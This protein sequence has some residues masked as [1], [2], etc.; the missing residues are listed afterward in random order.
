MSEGGVKVADSGSNL[1]ISPELQYV[2]ETQ[3]LYVFWLET[4]A[5]QR[6][7]G[8]SGQ[9]MSPTG[10]LLW[11]NNGSNFVELSL[12]EITM[13]T[14]KLVG[15]DVLVFYGAGNPQNILETQLEVMLINS[16]GEQVW[17]NEKS[18]LSSV[19]SNSRFAHF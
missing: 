2:P 1:Q 17:E 8:I 19:P 5:R 7:R 9:K 11:A 10:E 18:M 3:E 4:D 16:E 12:P 14:P 6:F 13:I 15:K